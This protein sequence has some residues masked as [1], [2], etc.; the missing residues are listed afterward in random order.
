M[1][2]PVLGGNAGGTSDCVFSLNKL[3][4]VL[5]SNGSPLD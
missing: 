4:F 3:M 2:V 5:E 1:G